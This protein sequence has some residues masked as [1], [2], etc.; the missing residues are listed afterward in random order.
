MGRTEKSVSLR[1][2]NINRFVVMTGEWQV[3]DDVT[4]KQIIAWNRDI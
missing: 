3:S 2:I 1:K 4:D